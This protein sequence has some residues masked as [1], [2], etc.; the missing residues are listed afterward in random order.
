M[1]HYFANFTCVPPQSY[2]TLRQ[3]LIL[4]KGETMTHLQSGKFNIAWFKLAEFVARKEKERAL[5]IYRLLT[6]GIRDEALAVQLEGDL[7]LAFNDERALTCY[8]RALE[9]YERGGKLVHAIAVGEHC[10]TLKPDAVIFARLINL[11]DQLNHPDKL[12]SC[13]TRILDMLTI[14]QGLRGIV[15]FLQKAALSHGQK[16]HIAELAIQ[17]ALHKANYDEAELQQ[18]LALSLD[19]YREL[20]D[21]NLL[22]NFLSKLA[23]VDQAAYQYTQTLLSKSVV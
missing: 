6:H 2:D 1:P 19:T 11:Y 14:K 13:I 9:L 17:N 3:K 4:R 18:F 15:D 5:G 8:V 22:S 12:A 16:A 23:L 20:A 10:V 21:T 7:L